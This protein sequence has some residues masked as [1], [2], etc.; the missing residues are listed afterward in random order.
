M[1]QN[2][3]FNSVVDCGDPGTPAYGVKWHRNTTLGSFVKYRCQEGYRLEG[4]NFRKC[5]HSGEWSGTLPTCRPIYNCM[6]NYYYTV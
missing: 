4:E 3:L 1:G 2:D 6:F 5:L